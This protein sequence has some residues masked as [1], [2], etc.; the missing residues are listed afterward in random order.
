MVG[1]NIKKINKKTIET[2]RM[3]VKRPK[4]VV[5]GSYIMI[6]NDL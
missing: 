6:E 1:S 2:E 3:K 4:A 5:L